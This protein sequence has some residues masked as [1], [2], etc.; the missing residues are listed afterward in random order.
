VLKV[1]LATISAIS[2]RLKES[3]EDFDFILEEVSK[4]SNDGEKLKEC[5]YTSTLKPLQQ[6]QNLDYDSSILYSSP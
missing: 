4:E 6:D 3:S 2:S 5:E 1:S